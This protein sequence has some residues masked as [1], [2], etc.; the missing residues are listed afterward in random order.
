[1][2][3]G[4][5]G[6]S[7]RVKIPYIG[8]RVQIGDDASAG[9]VCGRNYRDRLFAD[10]DPQ[11]EAARINGRE[12]FHKKFDRLVRDVQIDAIQPALLHFEVYRPGHDVARSEFSALIV[13]RHEACAVRQF[14]DA[15]LAT[16]R[17]TD[18]K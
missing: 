11:A 9:V 1:M 6:F 13:P 15:A 5:G 16:H 10:I 2:Q 3:S 18:Q 8:A 17:L 7:N 14:Q 4:V 12:V